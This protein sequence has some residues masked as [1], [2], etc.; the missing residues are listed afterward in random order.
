M[1]VPRAV[2]RA[3]ARVI[4]ERQ[5]GSCQFLL[6]AL[7]GELREATGFNSQ[8][9]RQTLFLDLMK[10]VRFDEIVETGTFRG[11][12]T[13]FMAHL[14][15]LPVFSSETSPRHFGYSRARFG[16][17]SRV[18]VEF[19][20]SRT[21]LRTHFA[22]RDHAGHAA[23][24]Y[25]DAHG[26]PDLPLFE[27]TRI[28]FA[29]SSRVVVMI[30]DFQVPDDPSYAFDTYG[31]AATLNLE[32]LQLEEIPEVRIFFPALRAAEEAGARRGCAV[33]ARTGPMAEALL[34]L[35]SLRAWSRK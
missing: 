19:S 33:L 28:L 1:T 5:F 25:L 29:L 15:G 22:T 4:G 35:N 12:T 3:I 18:H 11:D 32:Y 16:L 26:G 31:P 34:S 7:R 17:D 23:F 10:R 6:H 20:D 14:S 27:E 9:G 2:R 8:P 21:F 30:D 24:V 13:A